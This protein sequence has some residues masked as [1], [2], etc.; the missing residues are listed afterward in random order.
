MEG[1]ERSE[2]GEREKEERDWEKE[3]TRLPKTIKFCLMRKDF[4]T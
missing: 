4:S 3:L 2:R 1:K